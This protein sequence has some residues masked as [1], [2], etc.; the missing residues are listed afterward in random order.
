MRRRE[1]ISISAIASLWPVAART[2]QQKPLPVIGVLGSGSP[3]VKGIVLNLAAFRQGLNETGYVEGQ[4][5]AIEYRWAERHVER[6]PALAAELVARN[7]D[8]IVTEGG[9][10]TTLAAKNATSTIPIVYHGTSDPVALGWVASLDRPGGNLTGVNLLGTEL[11][12]K[13]LDLLLELAPQ[14]KF[15]GILRDPN[16]PLDLQQVASAKGVRLDILPAVTDSEVDA[17]FATLVERKAQGLMVYSSGR[18]RIAALALQ[19]SVPTIALFRD[20]PEAGGLISY[21][22]SIP[23]AYRVKGIYTGRILKGEKAADL[24]IERPAK[25]EMVVNLK[26]AKALSLTVPQSLLARAEVIE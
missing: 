8:V 2:Q 22:A 19:H 10:V 7:V 24:P 11:M 12:P 23:A 4:N 6:L 25:L 9:D 13:L 17:A 20:F 15:I 3:E 14:A 1:F 5:L 26:T 16:S 21:G 18:A